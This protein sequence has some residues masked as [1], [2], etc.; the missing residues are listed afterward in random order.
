MAIV[1]GSDWRVSSI[2]EET[3]CCE[4]YFE[5]KPWPMNIHISVYVSYIWFFLVCVCICIYSPR[6]RAF[7]FLPG[8]WVSSSTFEMVLVLFLLKRLV[9]SWSFAHPLLPPNACTES[10]D[11]DFYSRDTIQGYGMI[12][13]IVSPCHHKRMPKNKL[14]H[15]AA[16]ILDD[17]C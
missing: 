6:K 13:W 4:H 12:D 1:V 2:R 16:L 8:T 14:H 11:Y 9:S 10:N 17:P 15:S 3:W 5:A 7:G